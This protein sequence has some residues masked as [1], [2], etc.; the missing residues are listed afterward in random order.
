[1][2]RD[3]TDYLNDIYVETQ[4]IQKFIAGITIKKFFENDEK[5]F[6]V[7]RSLEIIGEAVKKIP[8]ELQ[9]THSE[10]NWKAIA[11]MRD[12]LIHYY[13]IADEKIIWDTAKKDIP[14]LGKQIKTILDLIQK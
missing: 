6:A 11:K 1:M 7:C 12:K 9:E 13:Y 2:I 14:K 4:R 8:K 10:I 3:I 5:F